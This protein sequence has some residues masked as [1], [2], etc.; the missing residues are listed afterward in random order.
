MFFY[1][2][3]QEQV[4]A[5]LSNFSYDPLNV[6]Y[7]RELKVIELFVESLCSRNPFVQ[8]FSIK[9]LCNLVNDP[10]NQEI[11]F[12]CCGVQKVTNLVNSDNVQVVIPALT[13]LMYLITP[14][15]FTGILWNL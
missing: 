11:I 6:H 2:E 7:L 4:L 12:K 10:L 15:S 14:T 3:S 1:A 9:G 5:N 8:E 13:T